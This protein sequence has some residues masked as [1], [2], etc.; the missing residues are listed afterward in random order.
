MNYFVNQH[1]IFDLETNIPLQSANGN[2]CYGS[3]IGSRFTEQRKI[4]SDSSR[5]LGTDNPNHLNF[6]LT[7]MKLLFWHNIVELGEDANTIS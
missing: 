7:R 2:N 5:F 6:P 4:Y 3:G 1:H